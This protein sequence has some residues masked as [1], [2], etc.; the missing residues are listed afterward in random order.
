MAADLRASREVLAAAEAA[1]LAAAEAED[2]AAVS[3][4]QVEEPSPENDH[5]PGVAVVTR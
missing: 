3:L 4:A 2:L 1:D 5:H